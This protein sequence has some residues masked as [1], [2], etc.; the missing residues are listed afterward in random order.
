MTKEEK[1]I[2][3]SSF[4]ITNQTIKDL[5]KILCEKEDEVKEMSLQMGLSNEKYFSNL[6][7][8]E[9]LKKENLKL[10]NIIVKKKEILKQETN[11]IEIMK[12]KIDNLISENNSLKAKLTDKIGQKYNISS[13]IDNNNTD[14]QPLFK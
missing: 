7:K 10:T 4:N 12:E 11:N 1:E 14:Y 13:P 9:E 2:V 6:D 8:I 5:E 3:F